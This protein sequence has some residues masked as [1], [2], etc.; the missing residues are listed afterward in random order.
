MVD[1]EISSPP[2]VVTSQGKPS[3]S[4]KSWTRLSVNS[5]ILI[6]AF[7]VLEPPAPIQRA[8][9]CTVKVRSNRYL[10]VPRTTLTEASPATSSTFS[11]S[12]EPLPPARSSCRPTS[13][14]GSRLLAH[15]VES[16]S[17]QVPAAFHALPAAGAFCGAAC[18]PSWTCVGLNSCFCSGFHSRC[19]YHVPTS[20]SSSTTTF[21]SLA[22]ALALAASGLGLLG[23]AGSRAL[24]GSSLKHILLWNC[25]SS[26]WHFLEQYDTFMHR[27]Q[28]MPLPGASSL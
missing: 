21:S 4:A 11:T 25:Q 17:S 13:T 14:C 16:L 6:F 8:T 23:G 12:K 18:W 10:A 24:A 9:T 1:R 2:S 15:S 22:L 3:A 27:V 7:A 20:S 26:A 19:L 5:R 28:R